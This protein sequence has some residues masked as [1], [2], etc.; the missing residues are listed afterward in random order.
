MFDGGI[1]RRW[2]QLVAVEYIVRNLW[3]NIKVFY[4]FLAG[5]V[6]LWMNIQH[7][8]KQFDR[9]QCYFIPY[10]KQIQVEKQSYKLFCF[11]YH[12]KNWK[13]S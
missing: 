9:L 3:M 12:S 10:K 7:P 11:I 4:M 1:W 13:I 2:Q 6:T 5:I 8:P